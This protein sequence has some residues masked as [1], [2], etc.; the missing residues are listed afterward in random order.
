M[1][2]RDDFKIIAPSSNPHI[3][4]IPRNMERKIKY[5]K[6]KTG[7]SMYRILSESAGFAL[8]KRENIQDFKNLLRVY[9]YKTIGE[10]A[11]VLLDEM[12]E[13]KDGVIPVPHKKEQEK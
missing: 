7:L 13:K 4:Y 6:D 10:W 8:S 1:A 9:G 5:A 3:C 11:V 12:Y 2:K